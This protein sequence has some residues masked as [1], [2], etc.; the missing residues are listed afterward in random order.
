[1]EKSCLPEIRHRAQAPCL[2]GA[3]GFEPADVDGVLRTAV[4]MSWA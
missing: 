3:N 1:M 2:E 4:L